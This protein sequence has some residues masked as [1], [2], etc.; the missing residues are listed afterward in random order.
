VVLTATSELAQLVSSLAWP[1]AVVVMLLILTTQ[2][3]RLLLRPVLRRLRKISGPGGWAVELSE[4]AAAET[5]AD[6]EGAIRSYGPVLDLEFERLAYAEGIRGR[7]ETAVREGLRDH[8]RNANGFRATVHIEDALIRNALY[9]LTDYWP[10]G[11]GVGRRF[12]VRFGMLGRSWRLGRSLYA[13]EVP[14]TEDELIEVWGMTRAQAA[15]AA[16]GRRS[17]VC[18]LLRHRGQPVGILFLDA[19]PPHAFDDGV[20]QR[21][22]QREETHELAAAVGRV[23]AAIAGKGPG[24]K[25]LS[26]D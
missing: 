25:L 23:R 10:S 13:P 2:R 26:D 7:L 22:D 17:F 16:V 4:D 1:V 19:I 15:T 6:V 18:V 20:E 24:L 11:P 12:S 5:K 9:Q 8:E 21:L 14:N 3:G